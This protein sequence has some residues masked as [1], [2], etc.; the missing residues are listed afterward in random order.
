MISSLLLSACE[1]PIE[2]AQSIQPVNI[3]V[4][5][6]IGQVAPPGRQLPKPLVIKATNASGLAIPNYLTNWVV[7]H[8]GGSVYAGATLTNTKG[9][10][11]MWWTL[12]TSGVQQLEVRSVNSTT[13]KQ[14]LWAT[15]TATVQ[16]IVAPVVSGVR[17]SPDT[18]TPGQG[19]TL[20][21]V[22]TDTSPVT[23]AIASAEYQVNG[24]AFQPMTAAD[25][26][27][28]SSMENVT[29]Q[30]PAFA[31]AGFNTVCVRGRDASGNLSTSACITVEAVADP[32]WIVFL[33]DRNGFPPCGGCSITRDIYV[34]RP[35]GSQVQRVTT[36][37]MPDF[38]TAALSPDGS[39]IVFARGPDGAS[40]LWMVNRDGTNMHQVTSGGDAGYPVWAPDGQRL[41]FRR[42]LVG[43]FTA[44]AD[45]S[46]LTQ[47][48]SEWDFG[49]AWS[50]DGTKIAFARNVQHW[51][52]CYIDIFVVNADGSNVARLTYEGAGGW[53]GAAL[54]PAWSPNGQ[55][56]AYS[57]SNHG[58]TPDPLSIWVM[59]PDGSNQTRLTTT[60]NS[61]YPSWSP[62]G[63]AIV[64]SS[65]RSGN[66]DVWWM[67]AD[68]SNPVQLTNAPGLD[69]LPIYKK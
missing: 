33:S 41:A 54:W 21:A 17:T 31:A 18:V 9:T 35:D 52:T 2:P 34:M 42:N 59:A 50:P 46:G 27:F 11:Q 67:K 57:T 45:G 19:F 48:T 58:S 12:G 43:I 20:L 15:C 61:D 4:S 28:N 56:I 55:F 47:V 25:G 5:G 23:S 7:T 63:S 37:Q 32:D 16:D 64:F 38:T 29:A 14:E 22:V 60:T 62:D 30:L 24:G 6:C 69:F 1:S 10:S 39:R 66:Q 68:G 65:D 26:A 13:G 8:G 44:N 51:S 53:C 40:D 49:A 36:L 3:A